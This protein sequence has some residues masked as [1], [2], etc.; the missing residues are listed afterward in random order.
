M[1]DVLNMQQTEYDEI[2]VKLEALHE[3]VVADARDIMD[4]IRMVCEKEGGFYVNKISAKI[5]ALLECV[6]GQV[7]AEL[8]ANFEAEKT[9]L[10]ALIVSVKGI[11]VA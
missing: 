11:D 8:E 6:E 3:N 5:N 4:K 7:L 10:E 2:Q 1:A 9:A